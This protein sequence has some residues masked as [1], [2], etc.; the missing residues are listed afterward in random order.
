MG[1][2][3]A[4]W[5]R[6]GR[7]GTV[8]AASWA[9]LGASWRV[10]GAFCGVLLRLGGVLGASWSVLERKTT[11]KKPGL[12]NER[13]ARVYSSAVALFGYLLFFPTLANCKN[14]G[15]SLQLYAPLASLAA[16]T[17]SLRLYNGYLFY[18]CA[19]ANCTIVKF[20]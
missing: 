8:L 15:T 2:L 13:E 10:L 5:K 1:R 12:A 20:F 6:L 14:T 16:L 4:S 19:V 18:S 17:R 7:L 9:V 3:G 11:S